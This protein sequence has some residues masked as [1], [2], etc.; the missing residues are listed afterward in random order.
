MF[1]LW[2]CCGW[3]SLSTSGTGRPVCTH[4]D[5]WGHRNRD[6]RRWFLWA[7]SDQ[8]RPGTP[9]A[10]HCHP[11]SCPHGDGS[12]SCRHTTCGWWSDC[13]NVFYTSRRA[14]TEPRPAA[15]SGNTQSLIQDA[16]R[17]RKISA[18]KL[19]ILK[20]PFWS[21]KIYNIPFKSLGS[22]RFFF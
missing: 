21:I 11:D 15:V 8:P 4:R 2:Q 6:P 7:S 5:R 22:V 19:Y 10:P 12:T 16:R 17:E 20:Q 18:Y 14:V 13:R 3:P 9:V 1:T